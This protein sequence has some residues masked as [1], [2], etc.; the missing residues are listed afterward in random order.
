[1]IIYSSDSL[2]A[3]PIINVRIIELHCG[4]RW[5]THPEYSPLMQCSKP[6]PQF[7]NQLRLHYTVL[8]LLRRK[9]NRFA[10][11][12]HA[13]ILNGYY[14]LN[15][16]LPDLVAYLLRQ[17]LTGNNAQGPPVHRMAIGFPA[18]N[19]RGCNDTRGERFTHPQTN[20]AEANGLF[21]APNSDDTYTGI[22]DATKRTKQTHSLG[23]LG[24]LE[25]RHGWSM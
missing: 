15:Y 25:R 12:A 7:Q 4:L 1:M 21:G 16:R 24:N 20:G 5:P 3:R 18:Q 9:T 8:W 17:H 22:W 14:R 19:L 6:V 11:M 23:S 10:E 2:T 13:R